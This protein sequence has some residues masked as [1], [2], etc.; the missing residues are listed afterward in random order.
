MIRI[1]CT[2]HEFFLKLLKAESKSNLYEV[3]AVNKKHKIWQRDSLGTEI[4]SSKVAKQKLYYLHNNT[5]N[6]K[7]QLA[8]DYFSYHYLS[9]RFYETG[10]D[11]FG[12]L[13]KYLRYCT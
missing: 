1:K 3:N 7:W 11:D 10:I 8:K 4:Y 9:A 2:V 5:V 12:F 6:R 13:K